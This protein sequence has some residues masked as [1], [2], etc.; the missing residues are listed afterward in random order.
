[1]VAIEN[2]LVT[3]ARTVWQWEAIVIAK[4]IYRIAVQKIGILPH[5]G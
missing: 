3:V 2:V 4:N 1:M 5:S